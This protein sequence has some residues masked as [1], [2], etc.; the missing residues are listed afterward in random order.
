[1]KITVTLKEYLEKLR[2]IHGNDNV[3]TLQDITKSIN[4]NHATMSRLANNHMKTL[5]VKTIGSIINYL[6]ERGYKT[7]LSDIITY[8]PINI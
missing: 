3:P 5:N 8:E 6:R 7:E 4:T 1:M 2:R